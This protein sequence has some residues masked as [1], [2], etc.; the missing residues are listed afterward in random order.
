MDGSITLQ[1]LWVNI[2]LLCIIF[3]MV[4]NNKNI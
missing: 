3:L 4:R 2:Q 1:I